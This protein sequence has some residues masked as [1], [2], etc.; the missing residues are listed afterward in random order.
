VSATMLETIGPAPVDRRADQVYVPMRDGVRLATDVYLPASA[1]RVPAVLVRLPYDKCGRYT[2][3][4]AVAPFLLDRGYAF[5]V[6]DVR[7]KFR[8]EGETMAYVH[9]VAD[10]FD[11]IEWITQQ[12]WS[13][14]VVGMFG[15]S[16]YGWTQWAAVASG[17]PALRAIVPR[18]SGAELAAVRVGTAPDRGIPPLYG[19]LYFAEHWVD[20]RRYEFDVDWSV[21]PLATVFD[22]AFRRIGARSASFDQMVSQAP[23]F[24]P[25]PTG[26]P[27][28][29]P[30]VPAL[31]SV[32]WFD[33]IAPYSMDDYMTLQ[34]RG[35]TLQ[36]LIADS[37]DHE[38]YRL[39]DVPIRPEL[40]HDA[41][42]EALQRLLPHYIG[43]ALDFYDAFLKGHP[44]TFPRVRWHQGHGDWHASDSWPPPQAR[45]LRLFLAEAGHATRD[46][47][48]G[49]LTAEMPTVSE[50]CR[51]LH[52]P[53]D[54][55]PSTVANPFAYLREQPDEREVQSRDDVATFTSEP[56]DAGLDLAG[57][58]EARLSIS[59]SAPTGHLYAK[60]CDVA[61]DGTAHMI[62]RG[63]TFVAH[64]DAERPVS[65]YLG[66]S[67]YRLQPGHR[68]R[69]HI[70]SSDFPLYLPHPGDAQNPWRFTTGASSEQ[71]LRSGGSHAA[72]LS[73][74]AL[75]ASR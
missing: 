50:P 15:D 59:S 37:T 68:L 32:G 66:H 41:S 43:P 49:R 61:G 44:S 64:A 36:Y 27:F 33:N 73:L 29:Q 2:F 30:E 42:D 75:A 21:R 9:E 7:G 20:Q 60:V 16:Y 58:L 71:E 69:L 5:I 62:V 3:M 8:S 47:D 17:H 40:D 12:V 70:A 56:F 48:G 14:G 22:E 52:R 23:G 57:P 51:W 46:V 1:G 18:V 28:S 35:R 45:P 53:D 31:H 39:A 13:N 54:L 67:G 24:V 26:H 19:G 25:Y 72:Y 38:N 4:P 63:Q 10:G 6:Q 65:I 74:Y 11:A 34:S 55:V